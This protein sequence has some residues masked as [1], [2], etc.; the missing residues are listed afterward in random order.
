MPGDRIYIPAGYIVIEKFV[1][2]NSITLKT[3]HPY[4]PHLSHAEI[5]AFDYICEE[6]DVKP[7]ARAAYLWLHHDD[8]AG[9]VGVKNE[10]P[11]VSGTE[12]EP[13]IPSDCGVRASTPDEDDG[14]C[15]TSPFL[16][17]WSISAG[18]MHGLRFYSSALRIPLGRKGN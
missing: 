14:V 13:P 5:A 7:L 9:A 15:G 16:S 17:N 11:M 4:L 3:T 12:G 8:D 10:E 2:G 1:S 18:I 6:S